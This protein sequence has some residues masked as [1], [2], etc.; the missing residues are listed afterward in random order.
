MGKDPRVEKPRLRRPFSPSKICDRRQR[1]LGVVVP[2]I[3]A[4]S[5]LS[6]DRGE[7]YDKRCQCVVGELHRGSWRLLN[8]PSLRWREL[9]WVLKETRRE[10]YKLSRNSPRGSHVPTNHRS[11]AESLTRWVAGRRLDLNEMLALL[12]LALRSYR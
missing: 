9:V 5:E 12:K 10:V 2:C 1:S 11:S 8:T 3:I 4:S 7:E 6:T